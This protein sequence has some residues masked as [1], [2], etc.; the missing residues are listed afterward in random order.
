MLSKHAFIYLFSHG[1]P[2]LIGFAS[3]AIFTRLLSPEQYGMYA[4]IVAIS[5]LINAVVFEWLKLSLLRFY[6]KNA[7]HPALLETIKLSFLFLA[8]ITLAFGVAIYFLYGG[9]ISF[10]YVILCLLLSWS[11]SW[12]GLNLS[13][14][15]TQLNPAAYGLLSFSRVTL[16]LILSVLFIMMGGGEIGLLGGIILAMWITLTRPT[17]SNWGIKLKKRHFDQTNLKLFAQYGLPLTMTM[18]LTV[19]I[20]NSDRLIIDYL[21]TTSDTGLYS[22]TYDLTEQTIFTFMMIINLAAFPLAVKTLEEKG[23]EASFEQVKKNTSLI[24][25]IALPALAGLLLLANNFVTIFL[26]A[27]FRMKALSLMP[28]IAIAA[29][30]K[31]LKLYCID[32]MFHL[33]QRTSIQ[34]LPVVIAAVV[35]IGLNFLLIP[36]FGLEGAAISTVVAYAIAIT[37]SWIIVHITIRTVPISFGDFLM[38]VLATGVMSLIIWPVRHFQ[39]IGAFIMQVLLGVIVYSICVLAMNIL[40]TR[41]TLQLLYRKM[42]RG[43]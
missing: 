20:H 21:M 38:I 1:I 33:T 23:E 27:D 28:Y 9:T 6:P 40:Q 15:R 25:I 19:V 16:G 10:V 13:L 32:I 5:G 24:L 2:A 42:R 7:D 31:G 39:G 35:N 4:L 11:Q 3:I 34:V 8:F 30:L 17:L 26:G 22:V 18:L 36:T 41:T 14:Y 37:L 29:L 12:N 43:S